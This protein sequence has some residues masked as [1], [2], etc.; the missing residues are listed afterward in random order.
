MI[1]VVDESRKF[2]QLIEVLSE[3]LNKKLAAKNNDDSV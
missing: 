1:D 2:I 3:K